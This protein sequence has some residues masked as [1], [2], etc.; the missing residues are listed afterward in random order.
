MAKVAINGMGR[1]GRA[2]LQI[3]LD[4]RNWSFS[5]DS[6]AQVP[7]VFGVGVFNGNPAA[8]FDQT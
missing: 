4:T 5:R 8:P 3:I 1:I 7:L 2:A 6:G